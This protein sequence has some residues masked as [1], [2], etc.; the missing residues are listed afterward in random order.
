MKRSFTFIAAMIS[1]AVLASADVS[2]NGYVQT[3]TR[4]R[5]EGEREFT[6]NRNVVDLRLEGNPSENLHLFGE[7]VLR[8]LGFPRVAN[9]SDLQRFERDRVAPWGLELKEAYLDIYS[10]LLDDLD[11]RIGKQIVVWGTADGIN[12]TSNLCPDDLEDAFNFGEKLGIN[13]VKA[14]FYRSIGETDLTLTGVFIPVFTPSTLPPPEWTSGLMEGQRISLPQ[15]MVLG[16]ISQEIKLSE[17][18]LSDT[19][20][21]G[22]RLSAS[23]LMGYDLSVSYYHGRYKLPI[24]SALTLRPRRSSEMGE[25]VLRPMVMEGSLEMIYPRM[26]VIGADMAGELLKVG[27]WAEFALFLPERVDMITTISTPPVPTTRRSTVLDDKP[28]LKFVLG[29]DYTFRDG[30]YLNLQYMHGFPFERG[31]EAL[32]DYLVFRMERKFLNDELKIAPLSFAVGIKDWEEIGENYGLAYIP[33]IIYSPQDNLELTLGAYVLHGK[34]EGLFS[35]LKDRDELYFKA[36]MS[37]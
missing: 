20:S 15:D 34:G 31:R 2:L 17:G 5:I 37:F 13:S 4:F 27:V 18:G 7:V 10:F 12:P 36:K 25:S 32:N 3:D 21:F 11:L 24:Q 35:R 28:Y 19:S 9:L 30:I 23:N 14:S 1:F 33:E 8:G 16:G 29:G 26:Q 22:V 6:W